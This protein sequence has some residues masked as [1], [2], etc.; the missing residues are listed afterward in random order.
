MMSEGND[1]TVSTIP[2]K[3]RA[4]NTT[5]ALKLYNSR[6]FKRTNNL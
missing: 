6:G 3:L 1:S 2:Q 4:F 5:V